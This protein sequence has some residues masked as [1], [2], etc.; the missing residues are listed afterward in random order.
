[1]KW[2]RH[3]LYLQALYILMTIAALA[4][5]SGAYNKWGGG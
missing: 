4:I 2:R 3:S 5:A 1:M